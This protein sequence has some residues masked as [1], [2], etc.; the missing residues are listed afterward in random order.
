[1]NLNITARSNSSFRSSY[2]PAENTASFD[3]YILAVYRRIAALHQRPTT[4]T[5]P[6]GQCSRS[7]T[8]HGER[9]LKRITRKAMTIESFI[10]W[11]VIG[12]LAG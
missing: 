3:V 8:L 7:V 12:A 10:I 4:A 9:Y 5:Q 1:L 6:I 2:R 11:L